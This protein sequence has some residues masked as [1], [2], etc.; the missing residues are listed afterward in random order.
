MACITYELNC[1]IQ[2]EHGF[3]HHSV[4]HF[5]VQDSAEIAPATERAIARLLVGVS[6]QP[7]R[8]PIVRQL[9]PGRESRAIQ[10]GGRYL[11]K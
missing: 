1:E 11:G 10:A 2:D 5:D 6:P 8:R 3:W 4:S 9:V 7:V